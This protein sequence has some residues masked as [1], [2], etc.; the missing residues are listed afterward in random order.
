[1]AQPFHS[2]AARGRRAAA[3]FTLAEMVVTLAIFSIVILAILAM[4]DMN[5]RIAR[6]E[7]RVTDMQQSLRA[8]QQDMVRTVRMAARGGL[9]VALF[10]D[11][12]SGFA[13]RQLPTGMAVEVA[14]NVAA[15]TKI[16]NNADAP[17]LQGSDVVTVRGVFSTLYQ[18]NPAGAGLSL[19]D[20]NNDGVPEGGTL[21]LNNTS[22]TGVPQDL[23]TVSDAIDATQ[24]GQPEAYLLV[25]PLEDAIFAVVEID[26]ASSVVKAGGVITQATVRFNASG[27]ARSDLFKLLSP[28][29]SYPKTMTTVAYSGVLEEYRYYIRDPGPLQGAI[30]A[31]KGNQLKPSL[32]RARLYPGTNIPY[33]N[34]AAN[35]HEEIADGIFDLQATL[36]IDTNGDGVIS[37]GTDTAT[38]KADEWLFNEA[39][40]DTTAATWNGTSAAPRQLYY[41]RLTALARTAGADPQAS[42]QA[43]VLARVED[44]DYQTAPFNEFNTAVQRRYRRQSLQSLVDLRNLS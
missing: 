11:A 24:A 40:D 8:G 19:V 3:G 23:Q 2:R 15:T 29:G 14:N 30:Q 12:L 21:V 44:K 38:R 36:G 1:M 16:A 5:G 35:L 4:F 42:W 33:K 32:V 6:V 28:G 17:V 10:P 13:G 39:G 31:N 43:P 22:P 27:T 18:S 37:E 25:S 9:P 7:G 26:P 20:A 34:D 41:V